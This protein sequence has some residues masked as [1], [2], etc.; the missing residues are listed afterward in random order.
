MRF[1][2]L[3]PRPKLSEDELLLPVRIIKPAAF[4]FAEWIADEVIAYRLHGIAF[5]NLI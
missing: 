3:I 2:E 5:G 1:T 4:I